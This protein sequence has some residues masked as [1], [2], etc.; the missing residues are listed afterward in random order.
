[1]K[2]RGYKVKGREG[3]RKEK[4]NKKKGGFHWKNSLLHVIHQTI[5]VIKQCLQCSFTP[6]NA[7]IEPSKRLSI[8][9]CVKGLIDFLCILFKKQ[10]NFFEIKSVDVSHE[11]ISA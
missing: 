9:I 5:S 4:K 7:S 2:K 3:R 10:E 11:L 1:M 8:G 6:S